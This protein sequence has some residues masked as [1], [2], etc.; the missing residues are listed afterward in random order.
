METCVRGFSF[1]SDSKLD[2]L[3][4]QFIESG[5]LE[6][7]WKTTRRERRKQREQKIWDEFVKERD[8]VKCAYSDDPYQFLDELP[9]AYLQEIMDTQLEKKKALTANLAEARA[10]DKQNNDDSDDNQHTCVVTFADEID[11]DDCDV[12]RIFDDEPSGDEEPMNESTS[13]KTVRERGVELPSENESPDRPSSADKASSKS[14]ENVTNVIES[15][16]YCA[17]VKDLRMKLNEEFK[18]MMTTLDRRDI[19]TAEPDDICRMLKRSAEF[20]NRFNRIYMYQ[21]QRQM[22]DLKRNNSVTLPFAKHTQFQSQMV[23]IVSLHQNLLQS[24]Q[25]FHKSFSQTCCVRE[26]AAALGALLGAAR[27]AS[28]L[29]AAVPPPKDFAAAADLYK[30]DLMATCEKFDEIVNEYAIRCEE[31]LNSF[32]NAQNLAYPKKPPKRVKKR[33]IAPWAKNGSKNRKRLSYYILD[34]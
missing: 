22:H 10:K 21:L 6:R 30:D 12:F 3:D 8:V 19:L 23:R 15:S 17:K 18:E 34:T 24:F 25:V 16:I 2:L 20:C 11:K 1:M 14:S 26:S 31:F 32:E 27:S 33:A 13:P 28:L 5:K 9:D 4:L 29:C 7:A